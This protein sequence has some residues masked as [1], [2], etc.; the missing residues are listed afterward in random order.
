MEQGNGEVKLMG[1]KLKI[2]GEELEPKGDPK[3]N[4]DLIAT[5]GLNGCQVL[6]NE[7]KI[8]MQG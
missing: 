4:L 1:V 8:S 7:G 3:E 6:L 5:C 2:V